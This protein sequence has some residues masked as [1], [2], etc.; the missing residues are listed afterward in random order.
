MP[1]YRRYN[2]RTY[3]KRFYRSPRAPPSTLARYTGYART[4]LS[5]ASTA[6]SA[7]KLATKLARFVNTEF[8]YHDYN[9]SNPVI[10]TASV[11][12]GL[13]VIQQ[14]VTGTGRTGDSI[15]PMRLS[16]RFMFT[17]HPTPDASTV[18]FIIFRGKQEDQ[19][20]PTGNDILEEPSDILSPKSYDDRFRTKVLYD[21]LITL[22]TD[23]PV[24]H[25]NINIKLF[26]HITYNAASDDVEDGGVYYLFL[27]DM[28]TGSGPTATFYS[29]MTYVDN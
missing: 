21:R 16:G 2:K 25:F 18:R 4:G 17:K 15:K 1:G 27:S 28:A 19:D 8:K 14:N 6:Y 12:D 20:V 3:R 11:Q 13:N 10:N 7:M 24:V 22:T 26:G 29:R 9:D 5:A 23:R